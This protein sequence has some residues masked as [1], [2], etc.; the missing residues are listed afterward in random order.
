[1]QL[2]IIDTLEQQA[3]SPAALA[4]LFALDHL[5]TRMRRHAE[6][7]T[8]LSGAPAARPRLGPGAGVDGIRAPVAETA[9]D[10]RGRVPTETEEVVAASVVN[11]MI[12]LLAELIENATLFSPSATKVEVRAERVANGFAIEVED[13]GLGIAPDQLADLNAR[14]ASPPDFDLVDA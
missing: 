14:L 9:D 10:K 7:L 3:A 8:V 4:D 1:R 2:R 12:H 11:D 5:T 13:R 6:S